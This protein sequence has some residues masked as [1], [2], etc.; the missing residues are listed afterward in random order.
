MQNINISNL[1]TSGAS[2]QNYQEKR[3][4]DPVTPPVITE[5]LFDT[6]S[7]FHNKI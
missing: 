1:L 3:H 4:V 5:K 2:N 7:K 6:P